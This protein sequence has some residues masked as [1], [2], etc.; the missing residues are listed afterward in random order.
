MLALGE[1]RVEPN[2]SLSSRSRAQPLTSAG[3]FTLGVRF[4]LTQPSYV[5]GIRVYQSALQ[6][7]GGFA[8]LFE[9]GSRRLVAMVHNVTV[10]AAGAPGWAVANI[11]A[12]AWLERG[13]YVV[14]FAAAAYSYT[15]GFNFAGAAAGNVRLLGARAAC[16][17]PSAAR[18]ARPVGRGAQLQQRD[19]RHSRAVRRVDPAVRT[20]LRSPLRRGRARADCAYADGINFPATAAPTRLYWLEPVVAD[21][22]GG[23]ARGLPCWLQL[24]P[25]DRA[26]RHVC[27]AQAR[28]P[29]ARCAS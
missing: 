18:A 29:R 27:R 7:A 14:A 19:Q 3:A 2:R 28:R 9:A 20:A 1:N 16:A 23:A 15:D 10:P 6:L 12:P 24:R 8:S 4:N 21:C 26:H 22:V 5:T 17:L 11:S 25:R 13:I